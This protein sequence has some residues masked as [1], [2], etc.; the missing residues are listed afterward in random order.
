M[1]NANFMDR[2]NYISHV[3]VKSTFCWKR[4]KRKEEKQ[5][6]EVEDKNIIASVSNEFKA[7][8]VTMKGISKYV[9]QW[10]FDSGATDDIT[11]LKNF[12]QTLRR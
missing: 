6:K 9:D 1:K 8:Y 4:T 2:R 5:E 10:T 7:L 12:C 3:M 11:P